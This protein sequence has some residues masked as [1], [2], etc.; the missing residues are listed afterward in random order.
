M[1]LR[2]V[3][4]DAG[5]TLI[6]PHPS[7]GEIYAR[8]ARV[9]GVE[10]DP[11]RMEAALDDAR[12]DYAAR[13]VGEGLPLP[14]LASDEQDRRMWR[15]L[16]RAT[17]DAIPEMQR[18]DFDAWFEPVHDAFARAEGWRLYPDALK[19]IAACRRRALAVGIVSNWSSSLP[20]ICHGLG[21]ASR[22]DFVLASAVEGFRKPDARIFEIALRRTGVLSGEALHVGD[23]WGEDVEGARAAGVRPVW[24]DRQGRDRYGDPPRDGVQTVRTLDGLLPLLEES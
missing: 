23:T 4:F 8:E 16:T 7:V 6:H 2:A 5:G 11:A 22:V 19:A 3:F 24:L 15:L 12:R 21:I 9:L 1:T 20:G 13:A 17:C 14:G 18:I 10:V